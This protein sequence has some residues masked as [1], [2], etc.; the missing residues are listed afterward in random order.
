[1]TS[2][3]AIRL[4]ESFE[5]K[6]IIAYDGVQKLFRAENHS[7][8]ADRGRMNILC[9]PYDASVCEGAFMVL[10]A[11]DDKALNAQICRD[12]K[13]TGAY[14]NNASDHHQCDFYFPSVIK[15]GAH[16]I[17][18]NG[19]GQDHKGTKLLRQNLEDALETVIR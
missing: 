2:E 18:I 9:K 4:V 7:E 14:V 11:T 10:A 19:G 1:M 12:A 16:V 8:Y 3:E 5:A 15:Q 13:R 17:G 6:E